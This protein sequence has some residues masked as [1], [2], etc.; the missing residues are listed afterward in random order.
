VGSLASLINEEKAFSSPLC[1]H[2]IQLFGFLAVFFGFSCPPLFAA[3]PDRGG[4]NFHATK[5]NVF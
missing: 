1:V 3:K 2:V 4:L 5:G